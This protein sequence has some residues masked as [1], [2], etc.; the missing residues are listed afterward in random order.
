MQRAAGRRY[1]YGYRRVHPFRKHVGD[2]LS[3][4]RTILNGGS[5]HSSLIAG[6]ATRGEGA[7]GQGQS[8]Q[9]TEIPSL[10]DG[11]SKDLVC[12]LLCKRDHDIAFAVG[13]PALQSVPPVIIDRDG[14]GRM[15]AACQRSEDGKT[16]FVCSGVSTA[17]FGSGLVGGN[18]FIGC[19]DDRP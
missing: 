13:Q 18:F 14:A 11:E 5:N 10:P 9:R 1:R 12:K 8:Q 2:Q 6:T 17:V 4:D 7:Y 3:D 19:V 15:I 16:A